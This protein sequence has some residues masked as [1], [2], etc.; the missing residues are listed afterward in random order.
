MS[1]R[2]HLH[3]LV[4]QI[5]E[6]RLATAARVLEQ[7]RGDSDAFL[8][9]LERG[10]IDDEPTSPEE[11]AGAAEAWQEY[12]RGEGITPDEAKRALLR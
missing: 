1:T 7:L 6:E 4:D 5:P 11:D 9:A 10:E 3:L 2:E 12:L 8:A